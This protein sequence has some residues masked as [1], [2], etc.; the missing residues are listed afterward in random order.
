[1]LSLVGV[2]YWAAGKTTVT[3]LVVVVVVVLEVVAGEVDPGT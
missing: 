1:M 3:R 2:G